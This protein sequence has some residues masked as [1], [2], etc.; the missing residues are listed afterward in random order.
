VKIRKQIAVGSALLF[1]STSVVTG[2]GLLS[3]SAGAGTGSV[4]SG[5]DGVTPAETSNPLSLQA[6][7]P[8]Q[9]M[10]EFIDGALKRNMAGSYGGTNLNS[11]GMQVVHIVGGPSM[12]ASASS[13]V[14]SAVSVGSTEK[15][16][17]PLPSASSVTYVDANYNLEQLNN[18]SEVIAQN[19]QG[20]A[21]QGIELGTWGVDI[22][23]NRLSVSV[24]QLDAAKSQIIQSL[25]GG[26]GL[27]ISNVDQAPMAMSRQTDSTP[28]WGGDLINNVASGAGCTSGF[29]MIKGTATYNET[30]AHCGSG[31]FKQN[32]QGYGVS[33]DRQPGSDIQL[34]TTYPGAATGTVWTGTTTGTA[35]QIVDGVNNSQE[36]GGAA[37]NDGYQWQNYGGTGSVVCGS[38]FL[39]NQCAN[40]QT[41]GT[42][43]GLNIMTNSG[44]DVVIQGDSGGP[45][46]TFKSSGVEAL[47]MTSAGAGTCSL[48]SSGV[49]GCTELL[50]A[51]EALIELGL[52]ATTMCGSAAC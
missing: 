7:T 30:A 14:A 16:Q 34:I 35:D 23:T 50:Y 17:Q 44:Q 11:S 27:E 20:L 21:A 24:V 40:I 48:M 49:Y 51:P 15:L 31:T 42:I 18:M 6:N 45:V 43:C 32:G 9:E 26:T 12:I 3:D 22:A 4:A 13:L 33:Y 28:W 38:I 2:V 25:I 5:K 47:G 37:C 52:G 39:M 19:Q 29:P 8:Q 46:L 10:Y 41:V 36:V 1:G